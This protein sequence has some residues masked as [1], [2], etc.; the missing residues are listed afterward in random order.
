[1]TEYGI[2]AEFVGLLSRS[3]RD[4]VVASTKFERVPG[5]VSH[6]FDARGGR[7]L[8]GARLDRLVVF[9]EP[10]RADPW[11]IHCPLCGMVDDTERGPL[12]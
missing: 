5:G 9:P 7:T 1:M 2:A 6:A 12:A 3:I 8:C 11:T 4:G 10:W